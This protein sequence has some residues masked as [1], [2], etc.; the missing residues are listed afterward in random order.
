MAVS[1]TP[2]INAGPLIHVHAVIALGAI[3][4]GLWQMLA[5]KG[6]DL[7]RWFG[8]I[9]VGL[10]G[11]VALSSFWISEIQ[12]IGRF[13]PIHV[14][15]LVTLISLPRAVWHAHRGNIPAHRTAMRWLFFAG[16][17]I[18][19]A[20]TLLPDRAMHGVLFGS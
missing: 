13:S 18:A 20:F 14:L 3:G 15:S 7:H 11:F 16:L 17:L 12:M 1:L 5:P 4:M 6:T 2:L 10:M 8:R 9:W 19:G